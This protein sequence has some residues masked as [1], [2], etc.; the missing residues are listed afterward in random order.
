MSTR[1]N[2]GKLNPD[3]TVTRIY[4]HFDGYLSHNGYTLVEHYQDEAKVDQLLALGDL[5]TLSD[6]I[7]EKQDFDNRSTHNDKWCLA[8]GRD[9]GESGTEADTIPYEKYDA[10]DVDY[11]YLFTKD[12]W[13]Y[14]S[15]NT[16]YEWTDVK[17]ALAKQ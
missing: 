12:G 13:K 3:G 8:Y 5:S 6:E 14:Q 4:C 17:D 15:Y 7:G 11:I 16:G 10:R 2:I 1:S 9:R